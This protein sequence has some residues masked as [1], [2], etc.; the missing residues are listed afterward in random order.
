MTIEQI[1]EYLKYVFIVSLVINLFYWLFFYIRIA[2]YK[3]PKVKDKDVPVNIIIAA[4]NEAENLKKNL[5]YFLEQDYPNYKVIVVNDSSTDDSATVLAQYKERYKNLYVTTIPYN[6]V[7]IHGKKTAL[8]IGIKAANADILLFS[9]ADCYP[10]SDQWIKT[11]ISE[12]DNDTEF[13]IGFGGYEQ[14]KGLLDKII[15][16][17]TV[18]IAM[19]Y[20][21]MGLAGIPYMA[22][23][24][25]MSYKKST[26]EKVKGFSKFF[27]L[28][29]GSD[30]LFVN[31]NANKNNAKCILS[32]NSFTSSKQQESY[33]KWKLQKVRHLS[34]S[35]YY[36]FW[37]KILLF[38]E[39]FSRVI[40][41]LSAIALFIFL[42]EY[43]LFSS[44]I[45]GRF[46]I[47]AL[48][49]NSVN[50]RLNQKNI[51]IF[52]IIF[53]LIQPLLN[54]NFYLRVRKKKN[55]VWK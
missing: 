10:V 50:K 27:N 4:R 23:G 7:C 39:P 2:F 55:L 53:D 28:L 46:I 30:D 36:K 5:P 43:Y 24:R 20:L 26:F 51:L 29:S 41:Y 1:A 38:F 31:Q 15:R 42:K 3:E 49:L 52:E 45:V 13:V 9:D 11:M 18:Y 25:N 17:D 54:F 35:S 47:I 34:T 19:N 6:E 33:K 21:G 14:K 16:S 12:Y 37:H 22:V 32:K 8:N 48:I 40:F 44:I